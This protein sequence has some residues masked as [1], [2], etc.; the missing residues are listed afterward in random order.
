MDK[1][2]MYVGE[3]ISPVTGEHVA[4]AVVNAENNSEC[5]YKMYCT[6]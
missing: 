6:G 5:G 2:L 1:E 3:D 4:Y